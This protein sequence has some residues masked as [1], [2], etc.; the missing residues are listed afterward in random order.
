[1]NDSAAWQPSASISML[2]RRA[3]MLAAIRQFFQ[4]RDVLEVDTPSL[5][6]YSVTDPHMAAIHTANPLAAEEQYFLQTS[7]EYAMKRLL[8]VG[9]GAIFQ[10]AKA[11]RQ[12]ERGSL[13]NP[14]FTLL[15]WYRPGFDYF[16]LMDEVEELV[17]GQLDIHQPFMRLS[18]RQLFDKFLGVDPYHCDCSSL[19]DLAM[20]LVDVQMQ[21]ADKDDWLNL[22]LAEVIEP[23]LAEQSALDRAV[24]VYDY[25]PSQASLARIARDDRGAS[26]A[27]RFELYV[28]GIELA[29]G[30]F[31]LG[32]ADEQL[33]RFQQDQ[34]QRVLQGKPA[35]AIDPY[36]ID[37][38][39]TGLPACSGVALGIDRLLMLATGARS[40]AEVMAFDIDRA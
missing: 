40:V 13:H 1:M 11:F 23:K 10:I 20:S 7:P 14:E 6:R 21:S 32:D 12:E 27:Q 18:Y 31:E 17:A 9:C 16:S 38:L 15:E 39:K 29:N 2:R 25:P 22:L 3:A 4:Q 34:Q 26:I 28:D 19:Q 8:A 30:F 5:C 24:F 33:K 36:L 37:A 35:V